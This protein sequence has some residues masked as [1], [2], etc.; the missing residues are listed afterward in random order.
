M[1][2]EHRTEVYRGNGRVD[3]VLGE[4]TA[5]TILT[6]TLALGLTDRFTVSVGVPLVRMHYQILRHQTPDGMPLERF[7]EDHQ[8]LGDTGLMGQWTLLGHEGGP[9][10]AW[11]AI[12]VSAPTGLE[13]DYPALRGA[14]YGEVLTMGSGTWDP[15]LIHGFSY[16]AGDRIFMVSGFARLTLYENRFGYGAGSVV[17][18]WLGLKQAVNGTPLALGARLGYRHQWRA[19]RDGVEVLNSGGDW[20]SVSPTGEWK[21]DPAW[22]LRLSVDLPIWRDLYAG[23]D[24]IDQP[25]NGQTDADARWLLSLVY[26]GGGG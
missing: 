14:D 8:G 22:R 18:A 13:R 2:Y 26:E 3:N 20:L 19:S 4:D 5:I 6:P 24:D 17:Q 9:A 1:A 15:I 11:A 10:A 25:V 21:V 7:E 23:P 12:G 16:A